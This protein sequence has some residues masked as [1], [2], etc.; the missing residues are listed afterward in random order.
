MDHLEQHRPDTPHSRCTLY[1][2]GAIPSK[3][4]TV[5]VDTAKCEIGSAIFLQVW[6][7]S[8]LSP[9]VGRAAAMRRKALLILCDQFPRG[10]TRCSAAIKSDVSLIDAS[11]CWQ[12]DL[13]AEFG[14]RTACLGSGLIASK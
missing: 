3:V 14:F 8:G 1:V 6:S 7:E 4:S 10:V 2:A 13:E 11:S 5:L 9:R 12:C